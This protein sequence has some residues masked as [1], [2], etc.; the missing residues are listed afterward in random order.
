MFIHIN[1]NVIFDFRAYLEREP[2][3]SNSELRASVSEVS[4]IFK[5]DP[6]RIFERLKEKQHKLNF[7]EDKIS[8]SE[9][10]LKY[11]K[12]NRNIITLPLLVVENMTNVEVRDCYLRS[13]KKESV[14]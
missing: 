7:V 3:F 14:R 5:L 6:N 1:G 11:F 13:I 8:Y 12:V 2:D 4:L 9:Q 10:C